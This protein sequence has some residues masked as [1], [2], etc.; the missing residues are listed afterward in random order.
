[1]EYKHDCTQTHR[2]DHNR[3]LSGGGSRLSFSNS[4][5]TTSAIYSTLQLHSYCGIMLSMKA[6][7][8]ELRERILA[9]RTKDVQSLGAIAER[10]RIPKSTVQGIIERYRSSGTVEPKPHGGGRRSAFSSKQLR[11]L[12]R[13]LLKQPDATL[14][15][16]RERIKVNASIATIHRAVKKLGFTLKK[17]RYA[18]RSKNAKM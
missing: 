13:R 5:T 8:I 10:F 3:G 15:Q 14:A 4:F 9:A 11:Q 17:K 16:L 7:P 2:R 1:M 18:L 12:K 6:T